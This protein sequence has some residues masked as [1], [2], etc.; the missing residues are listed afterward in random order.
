MNNPTNQQR[1]SRIPTAAELRRRAV[2]PQASLTANPADT[3]GQLKASAPGVPSG[4]IAPLRP[5]TAD[6]VAG[7]EYRSRYLDEIAPSGVCGRM[8]KF[9]KGG[10]FLTPD[11]EQ[12]V[13]P[14]SEFVAL[15][16]QTLVGWLKFNG[17]GEPPERNMGLLHDGFVMPSR[18]SLGDLDQSKWE[19]GLDGQP[20][21]PWTHQIYLVLQ[22]ASTSEFYT[23]VTSSKTGR[24]AVGNLLRHYDRMRKT[25]PNELPRVRLG[26]GGFEHKDPRVG[27]VATPVF[28]VIGRSP[29]DGIAAP[30]PTSTAAYLNDEIGF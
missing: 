13:P 15:C 7:P 30:E 5:R 1:T 16:D 3:L 18:E 10:E 2:G 21:D 12:S 26:T 28:I 4:P 22:N 29:R 14:E 9:G 27:H 23:F 6:V 20:Q 19:A 17:L 25:N 11:D 8:I 24:R